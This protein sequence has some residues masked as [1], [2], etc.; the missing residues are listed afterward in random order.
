MAVE[1]RLP[2]RS[3]QRRVPVA[4]NGSIGIIISKINGIYCFSDSA[5]LIEL[6]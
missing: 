3:G 2:E 1:I 5:N 4:D 6:D